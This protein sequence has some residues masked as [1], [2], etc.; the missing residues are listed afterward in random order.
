MDDFKATAT[1]RYY[2]ETASF[3]TIRHKCCYFDDLRLI[4]QLFISADVHLTFRNARG[5]SDRP[6]KA[7]RDIYISSYR[8]MDIHDGK[9]DI[10]A[11]NF[12]YKDGKYFKVLRR[13]LSKGY[14]LYLLSIHP[15]ELPLASN[16]FSFAD[17]APAS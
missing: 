16:L 9:D 12:G 15:S 6:N 17:N 5:H 3:F 1:S 10:L 7:G 13:T 14:R 11:K 4:D 8:I 2:P